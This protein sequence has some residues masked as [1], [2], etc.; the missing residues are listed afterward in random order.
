MASADAV[1]DAQY[2]MTDVLSFALRE[3]DLRAAELEGVTELYEVVAEEV[4]DKST[5][6]FEISDNITY[7]ESLAQLRD[8]ARRLFKGDYSHVE[9]LE[10]AVIDHRLMAQHT[11]LC[12]LGRYLQGRPHAEG[13]IYCRKETCVWHTRLPFDAPVSAVHHATSAVC[14]STPS[15]SF[16]VRNAADA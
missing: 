12:S 16:D 15:S 9:N 2:L 8:A 4:K 14:E 7:F 10:N 13:C 1:V 5:R 11:R 6:G 3:S